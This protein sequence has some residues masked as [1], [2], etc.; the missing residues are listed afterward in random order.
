M[1]KWVPGAR[2]RG[3]MLTL[4]RHRGCRSHAD[5]WSSQTDLNSSSCVG[6]GTKPRMVALPAAGVFAATIG[7][8]GMSARMKFWAL[9]HSAWAVASSGAWIAATIA[10]FMASFLYAIAAF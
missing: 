8:I 7:T 2:R 5:Y 10:S 9:S 1:W 3:P 4:D 6:D